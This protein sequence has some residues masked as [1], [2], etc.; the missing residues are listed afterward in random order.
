MTDLKVIHAYRHLYRGLLHAV[1]F[2]KPARYIA[3]DQLR[4]AFR[5]ERAKHDPRRI[6][7]TLRFLEAAGRTR[8]LEH[9]ILRNLLLTAYYRYYESL[10]RW[11]IVEHADRQPKKSEMEVHM[12]KTAYKHY[13]MTIAMLNKSM[14]LCL[15]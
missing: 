11:K 13:D 8:G 5:E 1:Q 7:R 10:T 6:A 4:R 2:S 12:Q 15:R 3:R 9:S 14:G